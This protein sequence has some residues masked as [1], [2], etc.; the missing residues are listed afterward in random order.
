MP[1]RDNSEREFQQWTGQKLPEALRGAGW[2]GWA[3][4]G[5]A[6]L[7]AARHGY[8]M[9]AGGGLWR[10]RRRKRPPPRK[11]DERARH[12][13]RVTSADLSRETGRSAVHRRSWISAG[14]KWK[15]PGKIKKWLEGESTRVI[16]AARKDVTSGVGANLQREH[17]IAGAN[18]NAI[19]N[20][21]KKRNRSSPKCR[22]V[23]DGRSVLAA[24]ASRAPSRRSGDAH[25]TATTP[26]PLSI[27]G[28]PGLL[29]RTR[30]WSK[31]QP[32]PHAQCRGEA[33]LDAYWLAV[34][35]SVACGE[36]CIPDPGVG[37][38]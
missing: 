37:G 9:T 36:E 11:R 5:R 10:F 2:A 31:H 13:E 21:D 25:T 26:L 18:R 14:G 17:P 38:W 19:K 15:R 34:K 16:V 1:P 4:E 12:E 30:R 3:A 7:G 8:E 35:F 6:D 24:S 29:E 32:K 22:I 33:P 23:K 20:V 27:F 28:G